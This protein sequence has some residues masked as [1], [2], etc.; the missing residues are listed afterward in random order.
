MNVSHIGLFVLSILITSSLSLGQTKIDVQEVKKVESGGGLSTCE[1]RPIERE[2]EFLQKLSPA[3]AVT[4]SFTDEHE[5]RI[6]GKVKKY[7]SWFGVVRGQW[8]DKSDTH[9]RDLLVQQKFFDGMTDCHIMLVSN[10]GAGDFVA[11]LSARDEALPL[12]SLVRV[13]GTVTEDENKVPHVSADYVRVW[14][15]FTFTFTD[16]GPADHSNPEWAKYCK[17]CKHGRVYRPFPTEDYYR[18]M[19]GDPKAFLPIPPTPH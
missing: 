5:Y 9:S 18:E 13:Y 8:P 4:G 1:Y 16:L 3:E 7:I 10:S 12:L 11:K 15:W 2:K 17:I 19:L 6:Q 14:P